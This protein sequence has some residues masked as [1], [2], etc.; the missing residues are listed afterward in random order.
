M[1]KGSSMG[2]KRGAQKLNKGMDKCDVASHGKQCGSAKE[3]TK[4]KK[5]WMSPEK[6]LHP[7]YEEI[8][9]LDK[10]D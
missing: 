3:V 5:H 9:I 8:N 7:F 1:S 2:R 10:E 6:E 4:G